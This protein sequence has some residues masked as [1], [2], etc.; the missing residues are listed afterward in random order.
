MYSGHLGGRGKDQQILCTE[1]AATP[2]FRHSREEDLVCSE[3]VSAICKGVVQDPLVQ[4]KQLQKEQNQC[5]HES[6]AKSIQMCLHE[7]RPL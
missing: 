2:A 6:H 7:T 3:V 1:Y 5:T 4:D